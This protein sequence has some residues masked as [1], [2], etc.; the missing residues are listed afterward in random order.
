MGWDAG[1]DMVPALSKGIVD[2]QNWGRFIDHTQ[3]IY[4]DD[5]QVEVKPNYIEFKAG[6]HPCLP[7]EGQ[8]F[9]RFS[10]KVTG[11]IASTT[12]VWMYI[13][14]VLKVSRLHFGSRV[15]SWYEGDDQWG[16]YN[17]L[18]VQKSIRSYRQVSAGRAQDSLHHCTHLITGIDPIQTESGIPPFE[19]TNIPGKGR[20]LIARVAISKGTRILCENPLFTLGPT[21]KL[22][23][24][25]AAKLKGLP[26]AEQRQFLSLH[27]NCPDMHPFSGIFKT[28]ALPCGSGS[29]VGG[30]YPTACLINHSCLPN[31]HHSWNGEAKHETVHATMP[32]QAG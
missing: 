6:E 21:D 3:K 19:I 1:F 11:R 12:N 10:S 20:G 28:N 15:Q 31:A 23:M 16:H 7:L 2:S 13:R 14:A 17:W 9:L 26:K 30:V 18:D 22:H 32:I 8:K 5:P 25:I 4:K 29:P 24:A 27:N